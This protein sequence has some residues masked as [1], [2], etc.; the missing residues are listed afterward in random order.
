MLVWPGEGRG[1]WGAKRVYRSLDARVF[2]IV[3]VRLF[4]RQDLGSSMA[5]TVEGK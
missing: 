5:V 4:V 1:R 3:Y 2:P